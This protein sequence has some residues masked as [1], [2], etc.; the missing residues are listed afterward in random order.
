MRRILL[1]C[2]LLL[3]EC[4]RL[5]RPPGRAALAR[6]GY[7]VVRRAVSDGGANGRPLATVVV[8]G[9]V[10]G[11]VSQEGAVDIYHLRRRPARARRR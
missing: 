4:S 5:R 8:R 11:R 9:F 10:L 7:L 3:A 2:A 1:I 6:P